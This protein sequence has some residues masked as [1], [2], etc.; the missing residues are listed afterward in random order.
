MK[1]KT[2]NFKNFYAMYDS[3]CQEDYLSWYLEKV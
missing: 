1:D 3:L 2:I